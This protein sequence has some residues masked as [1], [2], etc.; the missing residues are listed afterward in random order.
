MPLS[1]FQSQAGLDDALADTG[2]EVVA[3]NFVR[4]HVLRLDEVG[5]PQHEYNKHYRDEFVKGIHFHGLPPAPEGASV[6]VTVGIVAVIRVTS[7][8]AVGYHTRF[9]AE[10]TGRPVR[11][12]HGLRATV[13]AEFR[14]VIHHE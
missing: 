5:K 3:D 10:E 4:H 2:V 14:F 6:H 8:T 11:P 7:G 9:T 1:L 12:G 13:G